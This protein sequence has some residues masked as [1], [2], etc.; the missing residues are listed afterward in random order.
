[1]HRSPRAS[2]RR[3][4]ASA[5]AT[6]L[7]ASAAV[8]G[9]AVPAQAASYTLSATA[10][11][12]PGVSVTVSVTGAGYENITPLPGQS[13]PSLYIALIPADTDLG[14]IQLG[15]SIPAAAVSPDSSGAISGSLEQSAATLDRTKSY[16]V[17]AWPSRSNPSASNLY[18]RTGVA[19]DWTALF[20]ATATTT[21]LAAA[22]ASAVAGAEVTLTATVTPAAAGSVEFFDGA[23]SLGSVAAAS[24]TAVLRTSSLS[25]ADHTLKAAFTPADTSAYAASTSTAITVS[26]TAP[27][28]ERTPTLT[29]SKSTGLNPAGEEIT[30]TGTGYNPNQ[31]I[32]LTSCVDVPLGEVS[33]TF[34]SANRCTTGAKQITSNPTTPTMV[35]FQPDGSFTTTFTVQ[36]K[37][38]S[39]ALYTLANHTAMNDRTQDAKAVVSFAAV[40][41]EPEP[42]PEPETE[43]AVTVT[44]STPLD[45]SVQNVLTVT[46]TGF[47]GAG[48]ANGAYVL[49]GETSAWS[50]GSP[51][52]TAGWIAQAW[53]P[54]AGI[55]DGAFSTTLTVPAGAL[56]A[57][58]SYQVVTS[59]AHGL[60]VTDRSLDT[61]TP[62]AVA[63]PVAPFVGFPV[64]ASAQQGGLLTITGGGFQ[65][66]DAVTAVAHSEPV[67][68][69]TVPASGSGT[70]TFSWNVPAD[71]PVGA[72]TVEL[73]VNGAVVASA[74]FSVTAATVVPAVEQVA[75][76]VCVARA[77]SGASIDWGVK[78]SFR[79]YVTGSVANGAINGG[80]GTGSGAFNT[81]AD[82][83][84]VSFGGSVHYTGHSGALDMTL[85][86]PRI[87]I[88]NASSAS[89]ILNV[90]SKGFNGSPDTNASGIV[91]AT[92]SLPQAQESANR[93]TFSGASAT[94]TSAGAQAFA[95]FY[96][97]GTAL[98]AVTFSLP[99][100]AEVPCD[101]ATDSALASTGSAAPTDALWFGIGVI[102]F[103]GVL[104]AAMRRR[105][106]A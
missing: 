105:Q 33:F 80:W 92:L 4:L 48:A 85:S 98:D 66:G 26:I 76:P 18:A 75:A 55:V 11:V 65:A 25:I 81:E 40:Q 15:G 102:A 49:L 47:V 63:Q 83:G 12:D 78:E 59:A 41:P 93:V 31:P 7:V 51:L 89:L 44:P 8:F 68:I 72:H 1:M 17:I 74:P 10:A 69:G 88:N 103:G 67:T 42:E 73:S 27:P 32:Y 82:R 43:P 28:A 79:S 90:Q 45:P 91:F 38:G 9:A 50:G 3:L 95:G 24:G 14:S 99:L 5:V 64:G 37:D 56:D 57:S 30:V 60:S 23:A 97:A 53:V 54:S 6:A 61:F 58:K 100:G 21:T 52:P 106:R 34:I 87:Q 39:T 94:L 104:L 2:L 46:G 16:D 20:P 70:V 13:Q 35:A 36:P 77:V 101:S 62:V 96:E 86:N 19:I 71:F 29:L 22:P 84:R